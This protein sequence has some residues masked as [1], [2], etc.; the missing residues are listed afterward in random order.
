MQV[1]LVPIDFSPQSRNA[2]AHAAMLAKSFHGKL[3]L[4]HAYMLPTPVSEVPYVMVTVDDLQKDNEQLIKK[5]AEYLNNQFGV[6]VEWLVR[7]GIPSDEIKAL[8]E[9]RR[10]DLVVMGMKG[11]GGLDK[12]IGSTTTNCLRKLKTPVLIIPQDASFAEYK[13]ITYATDF[14]N[15]LLTRSFDPLVKIARQFSS[16]ISIVYIHRDSD[17]SDVNET[18]WRKNMT[19]IFPDINYSFVKI[20]D[21]SVKHGLTEFIESSGTDLLVM[22]THRHNFFERLFNRSQ[23]TTMAYETRVPLL[24]LH[25]IAG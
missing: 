4:F 5:E 7:I 19:N 16:N 9:E 23:T 12:L 22:L 10:I 15:E 1:I 21:D 11:V 8:T 24:V 2:A 3:L 18:D 6:E 20:E 14:H 13:H 25:D 17:R